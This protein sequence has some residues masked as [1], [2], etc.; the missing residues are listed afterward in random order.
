[1]SDTVTSDSLPDDFDPFEHLQS[2]YM[3]QHN[4]L[5]KRFFSDLPDDWKPNIATP[6]SSLRT[7]CTM[8]DS[9]NQLMMTMRHHLLFDL[10]GYGRSD[11]I[12]YHSEKGNLTGSVVGHPKVYLYFSQDTQS[13]VP[14]EIRIDAEISFRLMTETQASYTEAKALA[15]AEKVHSFFVVAHQGIVFPKGKTIYLYKDE[16]H[17][18]RLQIYGNSKTEI[19][20]IIEKCLEL[21]S[22]VYDENKLTISA[23]EK[24]SET[25]AQLQLSYG[26]ERRKKRFRPVANVR[27]RYAYVEVPGYDKHIFL[28]DTTYRHTALF[29]NP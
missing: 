23:P 28:V 9:D 14:G 8:Q 7:A 12:V 15:L 10:L 17:G 18:Y 24:N 5:V 27:F 29:K 19:I 21:Q 26:K 6:R 3:P 16:A 11:L 22:V 4:V 2:V 1:M 25:T 13:V 20:S